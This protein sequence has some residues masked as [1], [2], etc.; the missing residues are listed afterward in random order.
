MNNIYN[1]TN[2]DN[3]FFVAVDIKGFIELFK[4]EFN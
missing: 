4:K 1:I 2:F 3:N